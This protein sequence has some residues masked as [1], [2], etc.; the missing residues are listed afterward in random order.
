MVFPCV[1]TITQKT[2]INLFYSDTTQNGHFGVPKV[3]WSNGLGT[4]PILDEDGIYGLTQFSYGIVDT[5]ENLKKIKTAMESENFLKLMSYVK[6]TN[7]KYDYKII[8]T[9]KKDFWK[10]FINE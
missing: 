3:I 4:Y 1:Y 5:I 8:S 7:N 6:Y 2:G 9:F 10:E